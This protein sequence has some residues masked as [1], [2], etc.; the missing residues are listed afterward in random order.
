MNPQAP[1]SVEEAHVSPAEKKRRRAFLLA[2]A[3][4]VLATLLVACGTPSSSAVPERLTFQKPISWAEF[5][6]PPAVPSSPQLVANGKE[7][8]QANCASCHGDAGA[9][10]GLCAPFL[11][12]APRDLTSGKYRFKTTPGA[13]MPTDQDL[14][15]TISVGLHG[16]AMPPWKFLLDEKQRW[17]LVHYIKTFSDWFEEE[18]AGDPVQLGED[19]K[20]VTSS[21]VERGKA[22]YVKAGCTQ[23]HGAEGYGDGPSAE[24][25]IDSF[26][27]PIRP[28][29]FHKVETFKRGHTL[30][31]IAM[32][33]ATGNN[34][35]PM[36]GYLGAF[37]PADIWDMA[38]YVMSLETKALR[39]G[40]QKAAASQGDEL[41]TPDVVVKLFE[42]KW[43]YHP[44]LIRVREGQVVR[45]DF[46]PTDNG[47]GVGHG[48]AI[49]GYDKRAFINGAMVQRPKS[50]TFLADKPGK[51]LF[52]CATQCS[53]GPLHP[54]MN[55]TLIVE[56]TKTN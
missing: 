44:N 45:V 25:M 52:Y 38:A 32:T 41:G 17:A 6:V 8:F 19:P 2:S 49:D 43:A 28:R 14:F 11:S 10:D 31:D 36:P 26:D 21:M 55:G 34:G 23:C 46:Q 40:G 16:T 54:N 12:P 47:L 51:F 3:A 9:A 42:R 24:T 56:A 39:G 29:N 13:D 33:I 53:T 27:N 37:K 4:L 30:R 7:I 48:F 15:R 50:V 22:T 20:D 1:E 35:T 18:G 5:Q